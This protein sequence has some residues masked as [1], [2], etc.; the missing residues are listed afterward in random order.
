MPIWRQEALVGVF[1]IFSRDAERRFSEAD[2]ETLSTFAK[3]AAIAIENARLYEQS[4]Q[5]AVT[6]ERNRLAREI[7]DTLAQG[8][9]G[10]I[11]QLEIADMADLPEAARRPVTKALEYARANLL[12]ARRSTPRILRHVDVVPVDRHHA[13]ERRAIAVEECESPLGVLPG[14][15]E[16]L[17]PAHDRSLVG[18]WRRHPRH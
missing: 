13:W 6:E 3:H 10:I 1:A 7:H 9:T 4:Q 14:L 2:V 12:E 18:R 17:V 11:L 5:A 16:L 15:V 8:L